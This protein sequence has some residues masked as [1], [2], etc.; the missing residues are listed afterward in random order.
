MSP[1]LSFR[2]SLCHFW[3]H[4]GIRKFHAVI[5]VWLSNDNSL[6]DHVNRLTQE[7]KADIS[8]YR[9]IKQ[10]DFNLLHFE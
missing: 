6:R 4:F 1:S 8:L 3:E 7:K 5:I 10:L 2:K 9:Q